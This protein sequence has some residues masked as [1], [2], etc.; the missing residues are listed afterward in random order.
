MQENL[1]Q[2][3]ALKFYIKLG[4]TAKESKD[5]L[6]AY[7]DSLMSMPIFYNCYNMFQEDRE[8]VLDESWE[9][10]PRTARNEVLWNTVAVIVQEN[11]RITVCELAQC[12]NIPVGSAFAILHDNL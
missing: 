12:L 6:Q 7:G 1:E 10:W 2:S 9:G 4:K 8:S 5:M 11:Q 3:Y